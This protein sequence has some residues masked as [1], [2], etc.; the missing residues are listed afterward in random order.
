MTKE[1]KRQ[2]L[3]I[4]AIVA[5]AGVLIGSGFWIGWT[6]GQD[7]SKNIVVSEATN[8]APNASGTVPA[9]FSTFWAAWQDIRANSLW[10]P[11]TTPQNMM[12]G[13]IN[14]LA[15][16]LNDPYTEFFT[17]ADSN[18]FQQDI[19]GNFGGIGAELGEN[20]STE[21]V[22]I[23]PLSGTPAATAGLKPEDIIASINGS[24]TNGMT[25]DQAVNLIRGTI[26]T[27]VTL[28][29][30]RAGWSA[31]KDFTITRANIQVPTVTFKMKGNIAYIQLNEFTQDADGLF[32]KALTQA[33]TDNA[34][35]VVLDLR[36]D[37]GGYLQVAVDIAG[38]FLKPGSEVVKE[39]GRA[40]PTL[41]YAAQGSGAL[42]NI[43][44]AILMN[45]GTASA[46]EILSGALNDDRKVP[47]I[48]EK[49]FGKGTVQQLM[50]L[51]DGSSLKIT[52]AHW[53]LPSGRILDYDGLVPTYE[54]PV[55]TAQIAA[56]QDPQLDMALKIVQD[57]IGGTPLPPPSPIS[58][59]GN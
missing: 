25:V 52:V 22:I 53:V 32:Y 3:E 6:E 59:R 26:G 24:S 17:P 48:G 49:S 1:T 15:A 40:V 58:A 29:V 36:N 9:D 18:Q 50:N 27:N 45:N 34:Q 46:A 5:L 37:P 41:N 11:S 2:L 55:T 57:E 13:A 54:V 39:V 19:T 31:P 42:S 47:L 10:V 28:G 38:Y 16:S 7:H 12:Y 33:M 43:P 56:G 14:G 35:G 21:I 30:V 8:I 51:P 23:A 20:T 44:M 4:V